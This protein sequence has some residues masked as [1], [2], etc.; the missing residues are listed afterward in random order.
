MC[1]A[2]HF[3]WSA[4]QSDTA[5][6]GNHSLVRQVLIVLRTMA[7]EGGREGERLTVWRRAWIRSLKYGDRAEVS[8]S[9]KPTASWLMA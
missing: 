8:S 5:A 9:L 7:V 1:A 6:A 4:A 2:L 3:T